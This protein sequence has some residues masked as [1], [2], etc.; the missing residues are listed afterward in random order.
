MRFREGDITVGDTGVTITATADIS[1]TGKSVRFDMVKPSGE[2]IVRTGSVSGYDASY[3]LASGDI[4]EAGTW[5]IYLYN[6]TDGYYFTKESG[7]IIE[8]RPKPGDMAAY[9]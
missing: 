5:R 3:T 8:V 9:E 7:N 6:V 1:L 2:M 4:D